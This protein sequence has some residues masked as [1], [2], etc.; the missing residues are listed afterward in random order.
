MRIV[1]NNKV[2]IVSLYSVVHFFVDL[3]CA[4]LVSAI[5]FPK[6]GNSESAFWIILLYNFFAFATQLPFG[7]IADK[8]DKN[9]LCAAFGCI[10]V[11]LGLIF[12][13]FGIASCIIAGI[14]NSLFHIGGGIDVLNISDR[15]AT[16]S[17]IFVSTGAL[18]IFLGSKAAAIK[19]I[20]YILVF[21]VAIMAI[22]AALIFVLFKKNRA[23]VR[24]AQIVFPDLDLISYIII[25]CL[26]MTVCLRSYVGL[27][28]NYEWKGNG[29]LSL[30]FIFGVVF[31]KMLGGVFGDRFGFLKTSVISLSVSSI[32]FIFSFKQP[33][34]GIMAILL[35]NMTMPITLTALSNLLYNNKG[36]AFGI[37]SFSLFIGFLPTF[38]IRK[39]YLFNEI[40]LFSLCTASL[41]LLFA[42]LKL[43][44][45][46]RNKI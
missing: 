32:C 27:I 9:G 35:F 30:L 23:S 22:L 13:N 8:A 20:N 45:S 31:G 26:A 42:G 19:N 15:K 6:A 21:L 44:D 7:I 43:S 40:G 28:L 14:G 4:V 41:L 24:N 34:I 3:S 25:V 46:K 5:V 11:A 33:I 10:L 37:L 36:M 18:G 17:G 1:L 29:I 16:H 2:Q 12:S 38:L 39:D